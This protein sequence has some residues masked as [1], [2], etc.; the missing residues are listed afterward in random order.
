MGVSRDLN[1]ARSYFQRACS[2][3]S[4]DGCVMAGVMTVELGDRARFAQ[5]L[6]GWEKACEKGSY[7]G[8]RAAGAT[9]ALDPQGLG[10][11]RD[12]SRGRAYLAKA[13]ALRDL[14]A[15]GMGAAI[16][17]ELKETS[18]YA[19][20]HQQ[21][22]QACQ[23]QERESCHYLAHQEL[24]GTFGTKDEA[25]AA[26]HF[27]QACAASYSASCFAL[28]YMVANGIGVTVDAGKARELVSRSCA[29]GHR[30]A[31]EARR[32]P[33]RELSPP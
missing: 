11:P 8:C 17:V 7:A 26:R 30:P 21:L 31:C 18:S 1:R 13:C 6:D 29:L 27:W 2:L 3:G 33:E 32:H 20:A 10:T 23:L 19:N 24:E 5:V 22:V 16:V 14:P 28:A 4:T 15:C 9:L 25:S 12:M